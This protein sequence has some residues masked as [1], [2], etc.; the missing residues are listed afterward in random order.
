MI[1]V[2]LSELLRKLLARPARR[3]LML[4]AL[5]LALSMLSYYVHLLRASAFRG[6]AARAI[7]QGQVMA[8]K[9]RPQAIR[10]H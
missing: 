1:R 7:A 8:M 10:D 2:S 3:G 6:E 4:W 9:P 5:V